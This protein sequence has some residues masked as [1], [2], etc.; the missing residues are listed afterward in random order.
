MN[1]LHSKIK[2]LIL[3]NVQVPTQRKIGLEIENIIYDKNNNRLPVNQGSHFSSYELLKE[4]NGAIGN[5]GE[6]SLEP[7][8]QIEWASPPFINLSNLQHSINNH[9]NLLNDT[10]KKHNLK[11][12][13]YGVDPIFSPN[14]ID[15]ISNPKY[16]FMDQHM[17]KNGSMGKWMMRCTSSIQVN[18]DALNEQ[19]MEEIVFIADCLHPV[20]SYLFS[21]SPFKN[22]EAIKI[23]FR[24]KIWL[25]TDKKRCNSLF[26]H[27][28]FTRKN[29]VDNYINYF[30]KVPGIY[31]V[32]ENGEVSKT[33]YNFGEILT[34]LNKN[35]LINENY[36]L[37]SLR[38][39]FTNVRLKNL[40]EI[41]GADR[42]PEGFEIVPAAFWVGLLST[43]SV[44]VKVLEEISSWTINDRSLFNDAS[45][46]LDLNQIGPKKRT[47][48]YWV[49][50]F[51]EL[52]LEGLKIRSVE[53]YSLLKGFYDVVISEGPF[54]IQAQKSE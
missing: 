21:N 54:S 10:L 6:Y 44:R 11:L 14:E 18:F 2:N 27:G 39:I 45:L 41:R 49:K 17:D 24:N 13:P 40:V 23:N 20:A 34:S 5:N 38:Q 36:I 48:G 16:Q 33:N 8:G 47:Y 37:A 30:L 3:S 22:K 19:N 12:I 42:T 35:G 28:I 29:L 9:K 7:G 32:G 25:N 53:E 1:N 4:L 43:D 50:Y 31:E 46:I 26:D 52:S 51:G 15:L